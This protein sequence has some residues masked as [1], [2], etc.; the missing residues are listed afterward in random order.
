MEIAGIAIISRIRWKGILGR[1]SV[2][3]WVWVRV[4]VARKMLLFLKLNEWIR[5]Q[6]SIIEVCSKP[7]LIATTTWQG[8]RAGCTHYFWRFP[9][10]RP[11]WLKPFTPMWSLAFRLLSKILFF[12]HLCSSLYHLAFFS[13]FSILLLLFSFSVLSFYFYYLKKNSNELSGQPRILDQILWAIR[14]FQK[15]WNQ[16]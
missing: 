12:L 15:C 6:G 4:K 2:W 10:N 14:K 13:I 7:F 16:L 1:K 8:D 11:L 3:E 9:V 5:L